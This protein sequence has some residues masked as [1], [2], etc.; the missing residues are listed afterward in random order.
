M[1]SNYIHVTKINNGRHPFLP[2][3]TKIEHNIIDLCYVDMIFVSIPMFC[4]IMNET[5]PFPMMPAFEN[6]LVCK[7]AAILNVNM[8]EP[9]FCVYS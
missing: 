1:M 5:E 7:I 4:Y 9:R 3:I 8:P 6:Q 2:Q